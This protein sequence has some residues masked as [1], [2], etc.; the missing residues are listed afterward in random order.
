MYNPNL[1]PVLNETGEVRTRCES[2]G[3]SG[4]FGDSTFFFRP[5]DW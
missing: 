5:S 4:A 1:G 2:E 3:D